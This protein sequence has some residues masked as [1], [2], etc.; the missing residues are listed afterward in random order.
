MSREIAAGGRL[1]D[2]VG[3]RAPAV[4]FGLLGVALVA[5]GVAVPDSQ[6]LLF[7]WGGT[8]LFVALLLRVVMTG[9]TVPAAVATDIHAAMASNAGQPDDGLRYVPGDDGVTLAAGGE[10]FEPVGERLLA[11]VETTDAGGDAD[12]LAVLIDVVVNDLE[13]AG[14]AS[15]QPTESGATVTVADSRV[16]TAALFDHPVASLLGVGLAAHLG[17]P[18]TVE[19]RVDADRLVLDCAYSQ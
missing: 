4:L 17:T 7:A 12:R 16:G 5:G 19:P 18:V 10:R 2:R 11:G 14:R 3:S 1:G 13:L 8:A 15:A 9:S 6:S